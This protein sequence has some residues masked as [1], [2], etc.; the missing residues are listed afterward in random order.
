MKK[1]NATIEY[2]FHENPSKAIDSNG[3]K[4]YVC[5][6]NGQ[7]ITDKE[8]GERLQ[9]STT[10]TAIDMAG[11][12]AGLENV[13]TAELA[14][15]NTVSLGNLC[16]FEPVLGTAGKCQGT[17]K[18]NAIKLKNVRIR[19][20]KQLLDNVQTALYPCT[21][22]HVKHSP[23]INIDDVCEWLTVYFKTHESVKRKVLEEELGL[24]KSLAGKYIHQLKEEKK[25][26]HP[27]AANDPN[28]YP[29]PHFFSAKRKTL[30]I[31]NSL[32]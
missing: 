21:R 30:T 14:K 24:T 28:Y 8:I 10:I 6:C 7:T 12:M 25:L 2:D 9:E 5:I 31:A 13:I 29:E 19:P 27:G 20:A 32:F 26:L 18:G 22:V 4:C 16:R 15:G 1:S 17:E 3:A 11:V 23:K